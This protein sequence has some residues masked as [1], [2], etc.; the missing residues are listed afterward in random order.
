MKCS[1]VR[2]FSVCLNF[3]QE[4]VQFEGEANA[5]GVLT[6]IE[7]LADNLDTP[8][9]VKESGAGISYDVAE[10]LSKTKIAGIDVGGA[11][12][13]IYNNNVYNYIFY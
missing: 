7:K 5:K 8:V 6:V 2:E 1:T 10:R 13:S 12:V 3:L 11:N 4:A 9:I